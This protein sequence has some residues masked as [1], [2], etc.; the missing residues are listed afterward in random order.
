MSPLVV[1]SSNGMRIRSVSDWFRYAPPWRGVA[2]WKDGRSAKELAK[3]WF[4]SQELAIPKELEALFNSH[5]LTKGLG[6]ESAVPE[7]RTPLDKYRGNTRNHDLVLIGR[8]GA[9]QIVVGLEAKSDESFGDRIGVR[10]AKTVHT[11][12]KVPS[13]IDDLSRSIFGRP[14]DGEIRSVR[15]QLLHALAGTLIEA[16]NREAGVAAFVVHEFVSEETGR[17]NLTRNARDLDEFVRLLPGGQGV[18]ISLGSLVGPFTVH[19]GVNIRSP[20][21]VL[22]GKVRTLID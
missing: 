17:S 20:P 11:R 2:Q 3:A 9:F 12:S 7:L 18:Q 10:L 16:S 14:V 1:E 5:A 6:L 8:S 4:K 22:I 21:P 19:G 15:Y 13:R